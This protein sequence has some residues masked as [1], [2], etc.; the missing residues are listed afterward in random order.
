MEKKAIVLA[1]DHAGLDLKN[2]LHA[3][4]EEKGYSVIDVGTDSP[5]SMDYPD[6]ARPFAKEVLTR[7]IPGI[8]LCGTGIGVSIAANKMNGIR[9]ALCHDEFTAQMCREH[10]N[11]NV[12]AM[13][14]RVLSPE[15]ARKITLRFLET[16]FAGGRHE[17]R[18]KK[19]MELENHPQ[20]DENESV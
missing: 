16:A 11:A 3:M 1:C 6:L 9:A 4:L 17:R 2:V 19:L 15:Q 18:V 13:G 7:K 12:L 5:E 10:N 20:I 8:I 14:A